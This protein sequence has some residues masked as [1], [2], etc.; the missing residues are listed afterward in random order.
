MMENMAESALD[1]CRLTAQMRK[2]KKINHVYN[3]LVNALTKN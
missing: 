2:P 1:V 3:E